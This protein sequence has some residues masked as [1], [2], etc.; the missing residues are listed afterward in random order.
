VKP[1]IKSRWLD[2]LRSGDFAQTTASLRTHDNRYCCL[3]VLC[4]LAL[5]DGI[6]RR[7]D[8]ERWS[9]YIAT[10]DGGGQS[11]SNLPDAVQEWAG[12]DEADPL[13]SDGNNSEDASEWNDIEHKTFAQ[14]ADLIERSL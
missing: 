8:G 12:L 2:A 14:I 1:E 4:E 11:D 9:I 3:G 13:L 6:V 10:D 7:E 5:R